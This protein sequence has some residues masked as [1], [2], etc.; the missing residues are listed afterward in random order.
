MGKKTGV[1]E[2]FFCFF[3]LIVLFFDCHNLEW[4]CFEKWH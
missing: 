1:M 2:D 4:K 3:L